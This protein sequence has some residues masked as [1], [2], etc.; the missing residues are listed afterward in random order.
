MSK[1]RPV[2]DILEL[3]H[4]GHRDFGEN[5]VQELIEKSQL[6]LDQGISD[7]RWHFIGRLQSNKVKLLIPHVF[8]IHAIDSTKLAHEISKHMISKRPHEKLLGFIAVNIDQE[9]SKSGLPTDQVIALAQRISGLENLQLGG[10]MCIPSPEKDPQIAFRKL[11]A[12][13]EQCH[14]NTNGLLSMGMTSDFETAI[15]EGATHIRIGTAIFGNR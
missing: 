1:T 6:I 4:L 9:P 5:Y 2:E 13:E 7:I 10:L 8:A 12:L 11:R 3:Y 14:P 15:Q